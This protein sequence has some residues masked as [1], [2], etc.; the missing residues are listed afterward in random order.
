MHRPE[1]SESWEIVLE[2]DR[3]NGL[4]R[5]IDLRVTH[6]PSFHGECSQELFSCLLQ[7]PGVPATWWVGCHTDLLN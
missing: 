6:L 4:Q 2:W 3:L 7:L 1:S 5:F